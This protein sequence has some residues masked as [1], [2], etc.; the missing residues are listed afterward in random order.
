MMKKIN[1]QYRTRGSKGLI[2]F[3]SIVMV[4][5]VGIV[6]LFV[7][8]DE[9][10][11]LKV[12]MYIMS[13]FFFVVALVL[14]IVQLFDYI[15]IDDNYLVHHSAWPFKNIHNKNKIKINEITK[16]IYN[17]NAYEIYVGNKLF[18]FLNA[19][20]SGGKNILIYLEKHKVEIRSN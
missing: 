14:L 19:M 7:F 1:K 8:S 5:C 17:K 4:L 6:C 20:D 10:T 15:Y 11:V 3:T 9:S 16:V 2:I 13:G 12:I 18:C